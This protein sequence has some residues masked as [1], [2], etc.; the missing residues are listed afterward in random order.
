MSPM[1]AQPGDRVGG[2]V[3]LSVRPARVFGR[4]GFVGHKVLPPRAGGCEDGG[5]CLPVLSVD[6]H[7]KAKA[8]AV[9]DRWERPLTKTAMLQAR[10]DRVRA[11]G[12]SA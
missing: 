5:R 4:R 8:V 7:D 6:S 11:A 12:I 2:V 3:L 10:H 1:F 9:G